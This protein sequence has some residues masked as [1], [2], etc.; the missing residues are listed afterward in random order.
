MLENPN[1]GP[2]S[3]F[4]IINVKKPIA[5][6]NLDSVSWWISDCF[7]VSYHKINNEAWINDSWF[8]RMK[9]S[10]KRITEINNIS[11]SRS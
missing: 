7:P 11:M 2:K 4:L 1:G 6:I 10:W 9:A 8:D 5:V 3:E